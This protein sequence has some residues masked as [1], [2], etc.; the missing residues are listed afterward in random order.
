ME[1]DLHIGIARG[2]RTVFGRALI[3]EAVLTQNQTPE[4]IRDLVATLADMNAQNLS[5]WFSSGM[6]LEVR[7]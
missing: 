2:R 5:H 1:E 7:F 3:G 6:L 4:A